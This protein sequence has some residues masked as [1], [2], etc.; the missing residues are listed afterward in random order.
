MLSLKLALCLILSLILSSHA[1]VF[2]LDGVTDFSPEEFDATIDG[3]HTKNW[4]VAFV[5][6]WCGHCKT[7]KPV[8]SEVG[9]AIAATGQDDKVGLA[10]VDADEHRDF[11]IK[12]DV[13]GFPTIKMFKAGSTEA[14]PYNGP[15]DVD[16]VVKFLNDEFG[17]NIFIKK[18]PKSVVE[19]DEDSFDGVALDSTK[20]VLV[21]FYA[22]WCGHCKNLAPVY[23]KVAKAYRNEGNCVIAAIDAS[24]HKSI[25]SRYEVT[26]F[27]ALKFFG[28]G[29]TEPEDYS[30]GRD[31]DSFV[32]FMNE[33]CGVD[34]TIDGK[35]GATAGIIEEF[36]SFVGSYNAG[37]SISELVEKVAQS[38]KDHAEPAAQLYAK[39]FNKIKEKGSAYIEKEKARLTKMIADG[40]AKADKLDMFTQ[41]YNILSALTG[42][43]EPVVPAAGKEEL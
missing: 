2:G 33:K 35:L 20:N 16:G 9:V 30:T 3:T 12:Y 6:P 21:E 24:T 39:I 26:G 27:P 10:L 41:K 8:W 5:A 29:T 37:D 22:P 15:R 25:G 31:A 4:V 36:N 11:G 43:S 40:K 32:K 28:A 18:A 19:L 17:T 34:R 14:E 13:T 23:E 42:T 38:A 7:L 1:E